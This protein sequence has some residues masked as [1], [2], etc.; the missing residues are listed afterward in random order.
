MSKAQDDPGIVAVDSLFRDLM[1]DKEWSTRRDRGFTW[2]GY[3]LAQHVAAS[4]RFQGP[5]G[6]TASRLNVWTDLCLTWRTMWQLY[7]CA[8]S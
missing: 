3:R 1:V 5:D 6:A 2:W 4:P 8:P 7:A